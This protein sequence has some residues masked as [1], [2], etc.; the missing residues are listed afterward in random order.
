MRNQWQT[1]TAAEFCSSVRDGTHASP[2]SVTDGQLLITSRHIIGGRVDLSSAYRISQADFDET[3]RRSKVDCW[4]VLLSMIGTVGEPCLIRDEPNFA[5]KN[6][7][8]FKSRSEL[9]GKWLYY[10]LKS[11]ATQ[12]LIRS[13]SR[14]STQQYIPL[15][16]LRELPVICPED[17]EEMA[18]I[19]ETLDSLD[20]KIE[21]NRRTGSKLEGLAR[22]VFK[23]WFVDFEPVKAKA[24]GA[25]AFPSMPP[26][27][28]AALPTR[29]TN[30]PL[31]PVPEG[32]EVGKL[33]DLL[34]ERGER[35]TP[36]PETV[37]LPYVP[38]DCITTKRIT[39]ETFKGG[40][41][42]QSS[43]IRFRKGDVLF[44]AMRPYFHK[45]CLAPFEGTTRTTCFVLV[46]KTNDDRGFALMLASEVSTVEFATTHSV[47]STIPYAKW[48][49]S[50][51]DM[52]C[53]VPPEQIRC[54]FNA[55]VDPILRLNAQAVLESSK[56]AAL[57]D[58]LLP[59]LLSGRVRVKG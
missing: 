17:R 2:K 42:A 26:E 8:L 41:E 18:A 34:S 31:G 54:T 23:A 7:G 29:F 59:R 55:F 15:G 28:F 13:H 12:E 44:G 50:L 6:I 10:Y 39:L 45:V 5:I 46:P 21:Q 27:T 19:V 3:N 49:N 22:G 35:V 52:P 30:S 56:L 57:R 25:T 48:Q 47:G 51:C 4:D 40:E 1:I 33:G 32:W 11:P 53:V 37:A 43:L 58:Y 9:D 16:A 24:A 38:I 20:D 14:G 36:S